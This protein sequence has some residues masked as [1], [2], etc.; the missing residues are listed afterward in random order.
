MNT[1][2]ELPPDWRRDVNEDAFKNDVE[3]YYKGNLK[4]ISENN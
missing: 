3:I 2:S 1:G 4:D